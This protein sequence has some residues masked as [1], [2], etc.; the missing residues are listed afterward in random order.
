[1]ANIYRKSQKYYISEIIGVIIITLIIALFAGG[2]KGISLFI[3]LLYLFI[4]KM[5]RHRSWDTLGFKFKNTFKDLKQNGYLVLLV[6]FVIPILTVIISNLFLPNFFDHLKARVPILRPSLIIPLFI[7]FLIGG[8]IEELTFRGL[9]QERL[10][11]FLKTPVVLFLSAAIFSIAHFSPGSIGIVF[12][13][14]VGVFINALIYCVIYHRT[15]NVF[16]SWIAH[17]ISDSF[18]LIC[19]IY[20]TSV[21]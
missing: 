2:F 21:L 9:F 18:A 13:D 14:L 11:W 12:F 3:P 7:S 8:F 4:E 17:F 20:F 19:V 10:S 15:K 16:A 1:M 5:I 6:G